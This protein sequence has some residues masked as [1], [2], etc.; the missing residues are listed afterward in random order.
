MK[1]YFSKIYKLLYS[2][3]ITP[4]N[5]LENSKLPNYEYVKYFKG[6]DGLISEMKC[7][8]DDNVEAIF[9]YHFDANDSLSKVYKK[10]G[11]YK[12]L[13]FDRNHELIE[14]KKEFTI[15][16]NQATHSKAI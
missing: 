6:E 7:V 9:Y 16:Y 8:M 10:T 5:L 15:K 12:E 4:Y 1:D 2:P 3:I 14:T 11:P 13:V